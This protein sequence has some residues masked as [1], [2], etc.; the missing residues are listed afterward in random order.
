MSKSD[1]RAGTE[2]KL[3]D[4]CK[5]ISLDAKELTAEVEDCEI[6]A[7]QIKSLDAAIKAFEA[8]KP[9]P[10]VGVA[11]GKSATERL[12]VLFRKASS[13]L[14]RR[15][16]RL[17]VRFKKSNPEFYGEY[18]AARTIVDRAATHETK[19]KDQAA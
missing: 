13:L 15:L 6:T 10:R 16:D 8:V 19:K 17:M 1:V 14:T 4:R 11:E 5:G 2:A 18:R 9:K 7:G 12:P 3:I